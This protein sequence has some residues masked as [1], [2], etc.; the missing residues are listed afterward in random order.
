[1]IIEPRQA[2]GVGGK[3]DVEPQPGARPMASTAAIEDD[4]VCM[5]DQSASEIVTVIE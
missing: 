5:E 3:L 1:V 4:S 2:G